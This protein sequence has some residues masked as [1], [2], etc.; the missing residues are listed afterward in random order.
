MDAFKNN[1]EDFYKEILKGK[2]DIS[3]FERYVYG[4][5][6]QKNRDDRDELE[7]KEKAEKLKIIREIRGQQ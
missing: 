3:D 5:S 4:N 2:A 6:S 1:N 7:A